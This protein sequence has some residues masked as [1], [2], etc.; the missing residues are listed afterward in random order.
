MLLAD[1]LPAKKR[2]YAPLKKKKNFQTLFQTEYR[3]AFR[4][5]FA[6]LN[7]TINHTLLNNVA[8]HAARLLPSKLQNYVCP[9][10]SATQLVPFSSF[11]RQ[12]SSKTANKKENVTLF[13]S[14]LTSACILGNILVASR[15]QRRPSHRRALFCNLKRFASYIFR[16]HFFQVD[17]VI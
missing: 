6:K 16:L 11:V 9:V 12:S 14:T 17:F 13:S 5:L 3:E 15:H 4:N 1:A 10:L 7:A 2:L 8:R